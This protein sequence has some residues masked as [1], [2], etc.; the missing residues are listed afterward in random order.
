[1]CFKSLITPS[2]I[3]HAEKARDRAAKLNASKPDRIGVSQ[4][5]DESSTFRQSS[6]V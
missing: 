6:M 4:T 1:M 5:V 3:E 2:F